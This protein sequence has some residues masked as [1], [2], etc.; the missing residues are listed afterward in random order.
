MPLTIPSTAWSSAA[1]S[2]TMFAALPPSSSVSR[3][4]L[5]GEPPLDL[6]PHLGRAGE[7]DL[8]DVLALDESRRP[9][10]PSP[11]T[12]LTTPRAARPGGGRRRR[13]AP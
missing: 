10:R 11:V 2:K 12:M 9:V 6:L 5:P 7:G 13:E 1:S 4:P 3:L 8:V